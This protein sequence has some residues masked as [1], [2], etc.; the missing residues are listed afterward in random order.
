MAPKKI[1]RKGK[2]SGAADQAETEGWRGS[3]C[4]DFHLLGPVEE[5]L[6][7]PRELVHLRKSLGDSVPREESKETVNFQSHVLR[8]L[9]IP[10]SDFFCGLLHHWGIQV[11]HLTPNYILD[12]SIF[13]HL[14]E[15]FL[16]IESHFDL[17]QHL[18]HSKPQSN[19]T[20]IDVVGG[21]GLQLCQGVGSKYIP[22]KMTGKVID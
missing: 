3:K 7:Q 19:D 9:E 15:A 10:T 8:G 11:H 5:N 20:V 6:L 22:Y 18:F 16:G 17:F 2:A 1:Q 12:I 21:V 13:V 4:S 14:F